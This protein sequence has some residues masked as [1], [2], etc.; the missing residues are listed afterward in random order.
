MKTLK[1]S[2]TILFVLF[3]FSFSGC[4]KIEPP[5]MNENGDQN[6]DDT[7]VV[8]KILLEEFTGHQCPN[9]PEGMKTAN[10]LKDIYG[11]RLLIMSI[12]TGLFARP[13]PG[14]FENDYRTEAGDDIAAFFGINQYP[15]GIIN[16][17]EFDGSTML[18]PSGWGSAISQII[19]SPPVIKLQI[20]NDYS[21][22]S[23]ELSVNINAEALVDIEGEYHLSLFLLEDGI[24]SPQKTN[25]ED[26]PTGIITDYEHNHVLRE[27]INGSWG[28]N[29][30]DDG[31]LS[32]ETFNKDYSITLPEEW[33]AD[34]CKVMAII[35]N[36]ESMEIIQAEERGVEN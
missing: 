14:D 4:D 2:F 28:E 5:Y 34:N 18:S 23:R 21:S 17:S 24:I 11:N 27:A 31:L 22:S 9:C 6:D 36:S 1:I 15:V 32:G 20:Q 3:A 13:T 26:Y 19:D 12:H 8:R 10:Q 33:E 16:R 25:N 29:F 7:I 30:A 35:Y